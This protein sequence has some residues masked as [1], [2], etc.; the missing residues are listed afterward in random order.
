M[1]EKCTNRQIILDQQQL[2]YRLCN[3]QTKKTW[4][5]N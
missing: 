2:Q 5:K 4:K 3:E 1:I